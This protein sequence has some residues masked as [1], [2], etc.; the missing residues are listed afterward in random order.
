MLYTHDFEKTV[1]Y[2]P[3]RIDGEACDHLQIV[4]G[5]TDCDMIAQHLIQLHD[6]Q[7]GK[8]KK[9]S[10]RIDIDIILGMYKGT[11][12]TKRKHRNIMQ[13]LNRINA[14]DPAHIHTSCHYIYQGPEV[15][16][17]VYAWVRDG[18]AVKGFAG[19]ANYTVNAF[20]IRRESMAD[21][22]GVDALDYYASLFPDTIDCFDPTVPDLLKLSDSNIPDEEISPD[23]IENLT[24]DGLMKRAPIDVLEVS[25]LTK[26]GKVGESSGPNWGIRKAEGYIDQHGM[27]VKY[28]R[29]RNQAYL[30]YNNR[31]EGFFP[32][33]KDP[34]DKNCPL[35][36]AVTKDDGIF[37]MRM[38]QDNNKALHTAESNAILGA[39]LRKR[40]RVPEGSPVTLDDFKRYGRSSVTFYKFADDVFVMDF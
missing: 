1:L 5:F 32:D 28:N 9:Y 3:A 31:K 23:S 4:T 14:I 7:R 34:D 12:L 26:D 8:G 16:S 39:W 2:D 30:P 11:G 15:H 33:R 27:Y 17:K 22:S 36:K 40:L 10:D 37:Y 18:Q 6:E 21:C 19:S 29:D 24:Y 35:F 38:A 25:W 20:R 13:T